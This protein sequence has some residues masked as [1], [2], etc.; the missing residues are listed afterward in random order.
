VN[1]RLTQNYDKLT[2]SLNSDPDNVDARE[3]L[4]MERHRLQ[5]KLEN[6]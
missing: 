4:W 6:L 3:R 1:A 2:S 5:N